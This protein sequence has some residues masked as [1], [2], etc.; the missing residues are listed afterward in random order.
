LDGFTVTGNAVVNGN[1]TPNLM[2]ATGPFDP[3]SHNVIE[4]QA[5]TE[6]S[7]AGA[8]ALAVKAASLQYVCVE[9]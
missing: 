6:S 3:A 1:V 9:D 7:V 8:P 2:H 5:W 4:L